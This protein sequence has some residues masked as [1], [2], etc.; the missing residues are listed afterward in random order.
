MELYNHGDLLAGPESHFHLKV[1]VAQRSRAPCA[2]PKPAR[3]A[4]LKCVVP[5]PLSDGSLPGCPAATR[6]HRAVGREDAHEMVG[7][8]G[9]AYQCRAL[10]SV[11]VGGKMKAAGTG[12]ARCGG[13]I[14]AVPGSTKVRERERERERCIGN[15][16][17]VL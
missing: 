16:G 1:R 9:G 11:E 4:R 7:G 17:N 3:S 12:P 10:A 8:G 14:R 13:N 6:E 15:E 2:M 5:P